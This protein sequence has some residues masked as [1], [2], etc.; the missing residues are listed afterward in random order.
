MLKGIT[1]IK[2]NQNQTKVFF[3]NR[4]EGIKTQRKYPEGSSNLRRDLN[5]NVLITNPA[6]CLSS[7]W[8]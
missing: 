7:A 8:I 5:L 2:V 6:L 4:S 1:N 3:C